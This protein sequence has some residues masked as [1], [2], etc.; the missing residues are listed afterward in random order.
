MNSVVIHDTLEV[1]ETVPAA[2]DTG[3]I[4]SQYFARRVYSDT[5]LVDYGT[6]VINDTVSQ[7]RITGRGIRSK[8][9]I[10]VVKETITLRERRTVGYFGV[11]AMG[12]NQNPLYALG[13]S[14]GL[15]LKSGKFYGIGASVTKEGS[16]V[17]S[18]EFKIPIRLKK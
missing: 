4:L 3:R 6:V 12:N 5:Q 1:F 7:N 11:S 10:P 15:K 16:I 8:F 13:G 17:Y 14:F 9:S 18:A 2:V